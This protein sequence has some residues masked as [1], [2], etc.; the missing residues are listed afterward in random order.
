[1]TNSSI[2]SDRARQQIQKEDTRS[3]EDLH[4]YGYYACDLTDLDHS[5][6]GMINR[7]D[8][9]ILRCWCPPRLCAPSAK[10]R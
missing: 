2:N 10:M 4:D 9:K 7:R 1:M 3:D 6:A 8:E 5:S